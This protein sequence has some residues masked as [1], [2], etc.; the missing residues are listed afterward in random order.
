MISE[1]D[2]SIDPNNETYSKL[3]E[4]VG[5]SVPIIVILLTFA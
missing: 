3:F 5:V 2:E 1:A 4:H